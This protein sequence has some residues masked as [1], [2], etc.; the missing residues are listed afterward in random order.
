MAI[1]ALLTCDIVNSTK[2]SAAKEKKLKA[3]L[4]EILSGCKVEYY[5]GDSFQILV[6][7]PENALQLALLCRLAAINLYNDN[8]IQIADVRISI[9]VGTVKTP[10][11]TL[12][13]AKGEAF[14]LSGRMFD[15]IAK[16]N[17][18]IIISTN[19]AIANEGLQVISDFL[20]HIFE[21]ITGKQAEV[22]FELM[23]NQTQIAI[24]QKTGKTKSTIHQLT[25]AVN[26]VQIEK[27]LQQ[28]SKIIK[29]LM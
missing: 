16:T 27:L 26:W 3:A 5:R 20:N 21:K 13:T 9:G 14:I 1:K 28:Y 4:N 17:Q 22:L 24:A 6:D 8:K 23:N 7:N 10:I 25:T 18:R 11:K 15:T 12:S 19:N 2:L 29:L